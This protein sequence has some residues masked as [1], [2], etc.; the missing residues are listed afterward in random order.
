MRGFHAVSDKHVVKTDQLYDRVEISP[1]PYVESERHAAGLAAASFLGFLIPVS[2]LLVALFS[3][4]NGKYAK[5]MERL[6]Q[7]P[8]EYQQRYHV[9]HGLITIV[10]VC[11]MVAGLINL[12]PGA[13]ALGSGFL[14][15]AFAIAAI[16]FM[17][18]RA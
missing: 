9:G 8:E 16:P 4:G 3:V 17:E 2:L 18:A 7:L 6:R 5:R 11:G 10:A 15:I 13:I 14:Y 1:G 12:V